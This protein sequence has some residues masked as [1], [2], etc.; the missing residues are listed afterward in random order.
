MRRD[1]ISRP[2]FGRLFAAILGLSMWTGFLPLL[3][4]SAEVPAAA[5]TSSGPGGSGVSP[6]TTGYWL[7]SSRGAVF[8]YGEAGFFGSAGSVPLTMPITGLA[9]SPTGDGY[10]LVASDGG[11]FA[12][13]D[14]G[15][16]GSTG[17]IRLNKPITGMAAT[18]SG[19][20][21]WLVASD[22]GIFAFG[23]AG[24][25]G[26]TGATRLA[27]PI[28]GMATA[29]SG[30]GYWLVAADG[31][32]FAFG[33]AG[34]FGSVAGLRP[35]SGDAPP[36]TAM[37]PTASGKGYW[38]G[39]GSGEVFGFGDAPVLGGP[40]LDGPA[41]AGIV[42]MAARR[43]LAGGTQGRLV[44]PL[45]DGGVS[46]DGTSTAVTTVAAP[47][48]DPVPTIPDPAISPPSTVTAGKPPRTY[49]NT[50]PP[51]SAY[52]AAPC[53]LEITRPVAVPT[54][55][56]PHV[57]AE[58]S[59]LVASRRYPGVAWTHQDSG[60]TPSLFSRLD[61][62]GEPVQR[63]F[64]VPGA[65]NQDWEDIVY[66]LA[67]DGTGRILVIESGQGG[68]PTNI[69]EIAEPDPDTATTAKLLHTYRYAYPDRRSNTEAALMDGD[70]LALVQKTFPGRV[71]RFDQPLTEGVVNKPTYVGN[72]T[73]SK[74]VS[75]ARIS[76]DGSVLVTAT[77]DTVAVYCNNG[78]PGLQGFLNRVGDGLAYSYPN[79][80]VEAGD[81]FPAGSRNFLT[82]SEAKHT[83]WVQS[84]G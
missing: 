46:G 64:P 63:E 9:A 10:W 1:V 17:A 41:G 49:D 30:M 11:I 44:V 29:P 66:T 71:Y 69:Y 3:S 73:W 82:I 8:S 54:P 67:P 4:G 62:A 76:P 37:V 80:N 5:S 72:L 68:K 32:V 55:T 7:V 14:A 2:R 60:H 19:R 70:R 40:A 48:P 79:D 24:F 47:A 13:G 65:D 18:P 25:F 50:N 43:S 75:V 59:G 42:G 26:S 28:N 53:G 81:F 83:F 22:G 39:T 23:D 52:G 15:F 58:M 38:Q 61:A 56:P 33:D 20:G 31:G 35:A 57:I 78:T 6:G 74:G 36:V 45:A 21:Y 12:F 51:Y 16:F 84:A 34:F 77:H 27:Q